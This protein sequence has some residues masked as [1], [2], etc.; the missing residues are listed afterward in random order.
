MKQ[1]RCFMMRAI[2][3]G[4]EGEGCLFFDSISWF[5]HGEKQLFAENE[6]FSSSSPSFDIG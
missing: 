4:E 6:L 5:W 2:F 3:E 1:K